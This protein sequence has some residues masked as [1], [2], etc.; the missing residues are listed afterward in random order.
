MRLDKPL[1]LLLALALSV[2]SCI[3]KKENHTASTFR[4]EMNFTYPGT[5]EFVYDHLTG[6]ISAWWDHSFSGNPDSLYI[7][8]WPGGGFYEIFDASG[9]GVRHASVIYAK[10]GEMLRMEGPLGLSGTAVTLICTFTLKAYGDESTMLTLHVNGSGEVAEGTAEVVEGVW[11]HFLWER[12]NPYIEEKY[13]NQ[14]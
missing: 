8:A 12:F 11:E 14:D 4:F 1:P 3:S 2:T 10:R 9:D 5:P 7:E 6:D 13:S